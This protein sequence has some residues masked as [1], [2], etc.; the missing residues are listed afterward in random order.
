MGDEFKGKVKGKK[1]KAKGRWQ[2]L[3][4]NEVISMTPERFSSLLGANGGTHE[5]KLAVRTSGWW[6]VDQ[7]YSCSMLRV[8]VCRN[9]APLAGVMVY[10]N[11]VDYK[12]RSAGKADENG[13]A[14]ILAQIDND[15]MHPTKPTLPSIRLIRAKTG[16]AGET[17]ELGDVDLKEKGSNDA[18]A[19]AAAA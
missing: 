13:V 12:G 6:N 4:S 19:A 14:C 15:W 10:A 11:G 3:E 17:V 18:S 7:A 9:G 1:G 16:A 5:L 8:R 2:G